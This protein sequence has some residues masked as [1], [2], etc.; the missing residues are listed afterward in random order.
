MNNKCGDLN[1]LAILT[2]LENCLY[3]LENYLK[4]LPDKPAVVE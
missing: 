3:A 4:A 1:Y 2:D